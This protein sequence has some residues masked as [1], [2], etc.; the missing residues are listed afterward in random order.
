MYKFDKKTTSVFVLILVSILLNSCSTVYTLKYQD[1]RVKY[2]GGWKNNLENGIGKYY[3]NDGNLIYEGN[4]KD[5]RYHGRGKLRLGEDTFYDGSFD[6]GVIDGKG[7]IIMFGNLKY[8]GIF[9][10][11]NLI[12]GKEYDLEGKKVIYSGDFFDGRPKEDI[13]LF[14]QRN[15]LI[16]GGYE[17]EIIEGYLLHSSTGD[18]QKN[19]E[20]KFFDKDDLLIY[21]GDVTNTDGTWEI[22]GFGIAYGYNYLE[23]KPYK[24]YEGNWE[25]GLWHG[26]GKTF[27]ITGDVR[28]DASYKEGYIIDSLYKKYY[29]KN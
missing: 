20:V 24:L 22:E 26:E 8:D 2:K 16:E 21:E 3:D 12:K 29:L 7:K 14:V 27:W 15:D 9:R 6:N 10:N 19:S 28:D 18:R 1:G 13:K 11:G 25:K 4:W 17:P 5:G 23:D